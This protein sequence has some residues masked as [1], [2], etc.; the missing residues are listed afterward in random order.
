[1]PKEV[2][3]RVNQLGKA[4]G[5]P[6]LLT[7]YNCKGQLVGNQPGITGMEP[8]H[9]ELDPE[10]T[11][12]DMDMLNQQQA[13]QETQQYDFEDPQPTVEEQ[14]YPKVKPEMLAPTAPQEAEQQQHVE[15]PR[16]VHP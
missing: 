3:A 13:P 15:E 14:N 2:I 9:S 8:H 16:H 10:I 5:Q 12:V 11:G 1:M 6:K 7:F 4:E